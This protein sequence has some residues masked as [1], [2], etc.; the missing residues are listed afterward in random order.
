VTSPG[1]IAIAV[2]DVLE[3][4][5]PVLQWLP[6]LV[7]RITSPYG[8]RDEGDWHDAIDIASGIGGEVVA[9]TDIRINYIGNKTRAGRFIIA[10]VLREDGT[11]KGDGYRLT[12]AHLSHVAVNEGQRVGR[13]E[14]LGLTGISGVVTGPHLH[15][16][17]EK[18]VDGAR[19]AIDPLTVFT[20]AM[21]T[22]KPP[23][24]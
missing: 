12:F 18:V 4:K 9:P 23:Q 2:V 22:G 21:I 10:D 8:A 17:I 14:L 15:F 7:G 16:R 24:P 5:E 6:P 20:E 3:E 13:G 11:T 19:S 1:P